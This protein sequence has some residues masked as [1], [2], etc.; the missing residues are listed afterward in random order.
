MDK[1]YIEDLLMEHGELHIVVEEHEHVVND[2]E[3]DY[4]GIRNS[5]NYELRKET[6]VVHDDPVEHHI[7][8]ERIVYVHT[9][10]G[11]PD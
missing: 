9:P 11:F 6:I 3:E 5:D 8:Y 10:A 7:P 2:P 1:A 4:I